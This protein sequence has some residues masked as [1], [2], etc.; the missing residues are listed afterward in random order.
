MGRGEQRVATVNY[1]VAGRSRWL[2]GDCITFHN[3]SGKDVL[4][5]L[6]VNVGEAHPTFLEIHVETPGARHRILYT[7]LG[8]IAGYAVP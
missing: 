8:H 1:A 2:A 7:A 5:P 3:L 6:G 4:I